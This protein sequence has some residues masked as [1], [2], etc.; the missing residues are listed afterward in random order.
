MAEPAFIRSITSTYSGAY[1][2]PSIFSFECPVPTYEV[3]D[4]L[5]ACAV[6]SN[7]EN[8]NRVTDGPG[9]GWEHINNP[10]A[11]QQNLDIW[12]KVAEA[13]EPPVGFDFI[14]LSSSGPAPTYGRI[15]VMSCHC[16]RQTID[17]TNLGGNF[18]ADLE[19]GTS[20]E[21]YGE[22]E[23]VLFPG[24]LLIMMY[25]W[26]EFPP[27]AATFSTPY[28]KVDSAPWDPEWTAVRVN[29]EPLPIAIYQAPGPPVEEPYG[30]IETEV[31]VG[32]Y[33]S[34]RTGGSTGS[35]DP[36]IWGRI[37]IIFGAEAGCPPRLAA[38][39]SNTSLRLR[40]H[41]QKD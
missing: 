24:S 36:R 31:A 8:S 34:T 10:F 37:L 32:R 30:S 41:T 28:I 39:A 35:S 4:I 19:L 38:T 26:V 6:G 13:D 5:V 17:Q 25:S 15:L 40:P 14:R 11:Y 27:V 9:L 16:P 1:T 21:I 22:Q 3:G 12:S 7:L 2:G 33:Y 23:F 20:T 18:H 29:T